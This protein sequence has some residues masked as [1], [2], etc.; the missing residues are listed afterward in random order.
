[1]QAGDRVASARMM[2][3][4]IE[5]RR[6][7]RV[8]VGASQTPPSTTISKL[9][10]LKYAKDFQG[11]LDMEQ[12]A[13][14]AATALLLPTSGRQ[15]RAEAV[16][17]YLGLAHYE[18]AGE[19]RF[20]TP[21][22]TKGDVTLHRTTIGEEVLT[23]FQDMPRPYRDH[24]DKALELYQLQ[25]DIAQ[26]FATPSEEAKANGNL[27]FAY[28]LKKDYERSIEH[29][30]RAFQGFK[31]LGDSQSMM[32]T[33]LSGLFPSANLLDD[34]YNMQGPQ[35]LIEHSLPKKSTKKKHSLPKECSICREA[36]EMCHSMTLDAMSIQLGAI[37]EMLNGL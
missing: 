12:D 25:L 14:R 16:Y 22:S 15:G 29:F 28:K 37:S 33:C 1:V 18:L 6:R 36:R 23:P 13:L 20:G 24:V 32:F 2:R 35:G 30:R 10:S 7:D 9:E 8:A 27:G 3:L 34:R 31:Q 4:E 26:T 5:K 11:I 17:Y 19:I 21:L